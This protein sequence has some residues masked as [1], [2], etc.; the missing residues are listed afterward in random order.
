M[1]KSNRPTLFDVAEKAGVSYQ[2]VSRVINNNPHVAQATRQTVQA[3]IEE[4]GY[5]PNKAAAR[6]AAKQARMVAVVTFGSGYF[7]PA[8]MALNVEGA[9]HRAGFDVIFTNITD[10]NT[11]LVQAVLNLGGWH[12][13]GI[14]MITPIEGVPFE[15]LQELAPQT[16]MVQIDCLRHAHIPSV[17]TDDAIGIEQAIALLLAAGHTHFAEIS[18]PLNWH[19]AQ[20][21][22]QT[23]RH[24]LAEHHL[25]ASVAGDWTAA[26]GYHA[27]QQLL[28]AKFSAL[29]VGN[30]QMALG[31]IRALSENGLRVPED[32]SVVG[33]DDIPEAAYFAPPLTT[34]RQEFV[35]LGMIGFAYLLEF[36]ADPNT[37]IQQH[38]IA[39]RLIERHSTTPH[40]K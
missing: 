34:I 21:R 29:L 24:R 39:P 19:S 26:S 2:T 35:Q 23:I 27:A 38:R 8:Q 18:G 31:A 40:P 12:V 32:V 6:L 1:A 16:P 3:V 9:A 17:V 37:P 33:F 10:T 11:Q 20:Y 28:G 15:A 36:I 30:D 7:G 22:H 14:L 4:L 5:R 13:D 25:V